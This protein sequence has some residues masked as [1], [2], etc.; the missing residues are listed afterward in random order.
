MDGIQAKHGQH[1][2]RSLCARR[3]SLSFLPRP[4]GVEIPSRKMRNLSAA[5]R[6]FSHTRRLSSGTRRPAR[7][8]CPSAKQAPGVLFDHKVTDGDT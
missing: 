7:Q 4:A 8:L 5:G 3:H 2:E 1:A 6:A